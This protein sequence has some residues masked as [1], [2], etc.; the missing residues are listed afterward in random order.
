VKVLCERV[1]VLTRGWLTGLVEASTVIEHL[2]GRH[3]AFPK[4]PASAGIEEEG[5]ADPYVTVHK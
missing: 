2:E 1:V 5:E 3:L 4:E